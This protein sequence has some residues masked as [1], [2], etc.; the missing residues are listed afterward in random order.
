MTLCQKLYIIL[1]TLCQI[2]RKVVMGK[3]ST[4]KKQEARREEII[5]AC[6]K[7][8]QTL[9]FKEITMKEISTETSFTRPSIYNYFQTKEEIF[10]ALLQREYVRWRNDLCDHAAVTTDLTPEGFAELIAHSLE[11]REQLLKLLST[12][13]Y[14]MEENSRLERLTEFKIAVGKMFDCLTLILKKFFPDM[15]EAEQESF[16]ISFFPYMFAVYP[17]TH[18]SEKQI[19]A[20]QAASLDYTPRSVYKIVYDFIIKIVK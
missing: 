3:Y 20:M 16:M 4:E 12:N 8:Y 10:L 14:E 19:A 13:Y 2:L 6:E 11:K 5:D 9:S 1:L 7:L 17:Y 15:T 18:S